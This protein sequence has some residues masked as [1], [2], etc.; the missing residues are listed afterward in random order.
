M[1]SPARAKSPSRTRPV[2]TRSVSRTRHREPYPELAP[3]NMSQLEIPN[4]NEPADSNLQETPV[5]SSGGRRGRPKK[6]QIAQS[7]VGSQQ[8]SQAQGD[9]FLAAKSEIAASTVGTAISSG[10]LSTLGSISSANDLHSAL[11]LGNQQTQQADVPASIAGESSK[12]ATELDDLNDTL[13]PNESELPKT[14]APPKRPAFKLKA[15]QFLRNRFNFSSGKN[16]NTQVITN[17]DGGLAN[18]DKPI[19]FKVPNSNTVIVNEPIK[20][21]LA[22]VASFLGFNTFS[23]ILHGGIWVASFVIIC[24]LQTFYFPEADQDKIN[25]FHNLM[26]R[27]QKIDTLRGHYELNKDIW[28]RMPE[29]APEFLA[30]LATVIISMIL[31]KIR[32]RPANGQSSKVPMV[33][34]Y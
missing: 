11:T 29:W 18:S 7:I 19:A 17:E 34:L 31:A 13:P 27:D 5:P 33:S 21:R 30:I 26:T 15:G 24:F 28:L 12:P 9:A 3:E 20:V 1:K 25:L 23:V 10:T 2:R 8:P 16:G 22:R 32:G 14:V 6:N 4:S